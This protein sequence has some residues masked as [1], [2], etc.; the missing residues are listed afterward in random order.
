MSRWQL[1][2]SCLPYYFKHRCVPAAGSP[3]GACCTPKK[4]PRIRRAWPRCQTHMSNAPA[5]CARRMCQFLTRPVVRNPHKGDT[6]F[7]TLCFFGVVCIGCP[8]YATAILGHTRSPFAPPPPPP[9]PTSPWQ[10]GT[11]RCTSNCLAHGVPSVHSCGCLQAEGIQP[12]NGFPKLCMHRSSAA[13][14]Q[15]WTLCRV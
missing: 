10:H 1:L 8:H 6:H 5:L 4:I 9:P 3:L 11:C 12:A 13:Q 14:C 2:A 15:V 7:H